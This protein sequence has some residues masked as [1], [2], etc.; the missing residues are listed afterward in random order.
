MFA[1]L[2]NKILNFIGPPNACGTTNKVKRDQWVKK[3]LAQ[4]PTGSRILDAGA[5]E[6][7]YKRFCTNLD[8]VA[9]DFGRYNGEGNKSGLQTSN[10]DQSKLNIVSD[11]TAI[12]E[13]DDSF[14]AIMCT[15]VF[16]HLPNPR[17]AVKE[18]SRLLRP[19]GALILTAPFCSLTHFAP[20]H[21]QTGYNRY[22]Y[23]DCLEQYGF[24]IKELEYNGNYFEYIAQELRR[25][26]SVVKKYAASMPKPVRLRRFI[27]EF[28]NRIILILL[29]KAS[30]YE[31]GSHELLCFGLHVGAK[32]R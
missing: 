21:F 8:Y 23:E 5:G 30:A 7:Q 32:K 11:I 2:E 12:P 19:G 25:I 4:I 14:D 16:E 6:S 13:P 28:A 22:F 29:A 9:Q 31:N 27:I 26:P 24:D 18:F 3:V 15:E 17:A 10:W 1:R 20:Y